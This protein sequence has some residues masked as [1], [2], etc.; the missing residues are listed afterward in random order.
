MTF[1]EDSLQSLISP[2]PWWVKQDN[3]ELCR[4][5][6]VFAFLPHVDQIP[7]SFEP[8]GRTRADCH[9]F[10]DIKVTPLKVD[11]PLK[12][13]DLPVAAMTLNHN[14]VWAAYRAKKRPCIV[15][16]TENSKIDRTIIKGMPK[17]STAPTI[18]VAP[19]Y[20]VCKQL[21]RSGFNPA[22]VERVRHCEYPQFMWDDLPFV[23]GEESILRLDHIQ[24]IGTHHNSYKLS[25]Y[26]LSEEAL[27]I[28]DECLNL[29]VYGGVEE[30]SILLDYRSMI[31]DTIGA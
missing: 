20:G 10:A 28:F 6:L 19:Y 17:K 25:G 5:S 9:D 14:E 27:D 18:L 21:N 7:F 3:R 2:S 12:K 23:K 26:K 11:Q 30:D 1:P 29:S 4:G 22:F 13:T 31:E 16:A 8:I 15:V 24:P